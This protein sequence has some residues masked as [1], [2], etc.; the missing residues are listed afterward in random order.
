MREPIPGNEVKS[1]QNASHYMPKYF[2]EVFYRMDFS[3]LASAR[4]NFTL[5]FS[6]T[7]QSSS[8]G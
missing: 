4:G 6:T 8:K 5:Y 3:E 1:S 2:V 7:A